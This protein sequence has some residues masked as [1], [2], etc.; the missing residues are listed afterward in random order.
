MPLVDPARWLEI[1]GQRYYLH[2]KALWS[3]I[4]VMEKWKKNDL[5]ESMQTVGLDPLQF[6]LVENNE[7]VRI[8]H[9]GLC[10][11]VRWS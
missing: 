10:T 11:T 7:E 6:E 4:S 1:I 5:V 3:P 9:S 8:K 2:R